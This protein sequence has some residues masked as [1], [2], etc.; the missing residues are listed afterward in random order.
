MTRTDFNDIIHNSYR[1]LFRIAFR[2]LGNEQEAEDVIQEIFMKMWL[3][4]D[5]LDEYNDKE[6]L[7]VTMTRNYSIDLLRK[8]KRISETLKD[9]EIPVSDHSASPF[10]IL[11]NRET[12]S[13]LNSIINNLPDPAREIVVM[14]EINGLSYEEISAITSTNINSLRVT[15]SRARQIIREKYTQHFHERR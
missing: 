10:E 5:K 3:M 15:I 2:V 4:K 1:K 7:A 14:R 11:S 8:R 6:A 12:M 9:S 13:V